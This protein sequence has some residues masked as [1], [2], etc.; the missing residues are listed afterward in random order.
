MNCSLLLL[1][2]GI[3]VCSCSRPER[4]NSRPQ[5]SDSRFP[6][7][8]D[9][10]LE[11]KLYY[12]ADTVIRRNDTVFVVNNRLDTTVVE[13]GIFTYM[14]SSYP[15]MTPN[16]LTNLIKQAIQAEKTG[17]SPLATK[18]YQAVVS[19]YQDDWTQRKGGFENGGFSDLN[20]YYQSNV[21]V[22][23][24]V[25]YAYERL[26]R[27]PEA[28]QVLAPFLANAETDHTKIH[29]RFI[30]LCVRHY[31]RAATK[32]VLDECGRTVNRLADAPPEADCWRVS[33]FGGQIE[34]ASF[35]RETLTP[36]EAQQLVWEQDF[37][38][39]VK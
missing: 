36:A 12:F 33:V 25:S 11:E 38:K 4:P 26:G 24:L 10:D 32:R 9:C 3:A 8:P 1:L 5:L 39:L 14:R 15:V 17:N 35:D 23:T 37:Y 20:D 28:I 27:L 18:H 19:F 7:C 6:E 16:Y 31:G 21:N 2:L 30:E 22:T 34:V 13:T 29:L